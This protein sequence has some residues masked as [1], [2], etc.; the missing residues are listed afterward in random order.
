[1]EPSLALSLRSTAT[2][3]ETPPPKHDTSEH[4]I[5]GAHNEFIALLGSSGVI[6]DP[7]QC[8]ARSTNPWS[9]SLPSQ[10]AALIVLP[11]S[12]SDV[13]AIMKICSRRRI[14]VTAYCGGT[15]FSGA[16]T[17]TRGG[18]CIDFRRMNRI[19]AVH[20][21]DMDVVV[22]PGVGWQDLNAQL[23]PQ[24]L[25]FP[26]DPGPGAQIGGM[27]S[28]CHCVGACKGKELTGH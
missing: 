14:P 5:S 1:M 6:S 13:S 24:G 4:N 27:V 21:E 22:Q 17:A 20:A 16:L 26:P 19:L 15:S 23:A 9:P 10:A 8:Q 11:A 2:L 3:S 7:E 12:T 28:L 18:I 25:F